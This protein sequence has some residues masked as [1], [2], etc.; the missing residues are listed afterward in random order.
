MLGKETEQRYKDN[1]YEMKSEIERGKYVDRER[2][3]NGGSKR[4]R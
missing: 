4:E 2:Q 3:I 1:D